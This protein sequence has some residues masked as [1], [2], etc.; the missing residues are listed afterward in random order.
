MGR[1]VSFD[2]PPRKI[3]SLVP[4]QTEL[5]F[6]LGLDEEVA[7]I[8]KFC[9]HPKEKWKSK[10][11]VGGTKKYHFDKIAALKPDLII[12]NKE[13][14][15]KKQITELADIYPVWMSDIKTVED[16]LEMILLLGELIDKKIKSTELVGQIKSAFHKINNSA[17]GKEKLKSAFFIWKN[18]YMVAGADTFINEMIKLA[19]FENI[20]SNK[21]RYPEITLSE[22]NALN[23]D[24][25]LL[26]SEPFPFATKHIAEFQN[27]CQHAVIK[28]VDG[29]MFSWYGSRM[30]KAAEYFVN[31][32]NELLI[33][34]S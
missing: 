33:A 2:F 17:T 22:L 18:P 12:G 24:L 15:E 21:K 3:I 29:E 6:D 1:K 34:D 26:S 10:P 25:I 11:R 30:L 14:N 4:S 7:G 23:P 20:F 16:A 9:V 31:L 5:L 8:T 27:E 28:L 32:R 13:E 19:G